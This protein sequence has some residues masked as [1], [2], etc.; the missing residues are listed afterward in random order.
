M[1]EERLGLKEKSL[2]AHFVRRSGAAALA[3]TGISM[4]NL[5]QAG[6][7]AALEKKGN[8]IEKS[9]GTKRRAGDNN[10]ECSNNNNDSGSNNDN[11]YS[12]TDQMEETA[13][14]TFPAA[15]LCNNKQQKQ[16][17]NDVTH[18]ESLATFP[19]PPAV[20]IV[21]LTFSEM[22]KIICSK[23]ASGHLNISNCMF[24][25]GTRTTEMKQVEVGKSPTH[26]PVPN[27][28]MH[29]RPKNPYV[30]SKKPTNTVFQSYVI[31]ST[32]TGIEPPI[33]NPHNF[34]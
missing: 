10:T 30:T 18:K 25:L 1:I 12:K 2:T 9:S 14:L 31:T 11:D 4:P 34:T 8:S 3:N 19:L 27:I 7:K 26:L 17:K 28:P 29:T 16:V 33:N 5:Q 24:N 20:L 13:S 21:A 15:M 22:L 6:R 23:L 32:P